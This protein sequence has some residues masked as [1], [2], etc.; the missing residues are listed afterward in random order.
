MYEIINDIFKW[1]DCQHCGDEWEYQCE[2]CEKAEEEE[3]H[4][5]EMDNIKWLPLL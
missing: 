1:K 2:E 5:K 3:K 4:I